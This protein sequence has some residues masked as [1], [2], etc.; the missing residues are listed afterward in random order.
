MGRLTQED[1]LGNWKVKGVAWEN[2]HEGQV[3][4][5]ETYE[6]LYGCLCKLKDY[7]ASGYSPD[8]LS[9]IISKP[10]TQANRIRAMSEVELANFLDN[11]F[12]GFF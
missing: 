1:D 6:K 7:E 9:G 2:L 11:V 3:I 8:E 5:K 12:N 4:T 10:A